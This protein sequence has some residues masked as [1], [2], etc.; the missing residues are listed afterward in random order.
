VSVEQ[1]Q[2]MNSIARLAAPVLVIGGSRDA[3]TSEAETRELFAAAA[4]PRELWIVQGAAHQD[5]SR[6][7]PEAYDT[8]VVAF[9]R[10]WL[11]KSVSGRT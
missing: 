11:A 5:F 4:E 3:Y 8:H 7:D 2:P 9:L 10:K 6:F 1:L